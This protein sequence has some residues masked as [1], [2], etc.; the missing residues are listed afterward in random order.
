MSSPSDKDGITVTADELKKENTWEQYGWDMEA[1]WKLGE[2][3]YPIPRAAGEIAPVRLSG[4]GTSADPYQLKNAEDLL[5]VTVRLNRDDA[6]LQGKCF[7]LTDDIT[8]TEDFP[9]IEF[10]SGVLDGDGHAI[11]N[12]VINDTNTA[13]V[14]QYRLGLSAR[15]PAPFK[16]WCLITPRSQARP[17]AALT[18]IPALRSS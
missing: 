1:A 6:R 14:K 17:T 13:S 8:L 2:N 3:G 18:A 5:Y 12:L 4:A 9:M 10:F 11:K 7:V 16:T 15:F